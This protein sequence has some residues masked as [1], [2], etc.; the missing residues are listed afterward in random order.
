MRIPFEKI[1]DIN[2]SKSLWRIAV[3]VKDLWLVRHGKSNKQHLEMVI[4]DDLGDE[5]QLTLPTEFYEKLKNE[6]QLNMT[7]TLQNFDVEKNKDKIRACAHPFKLVCTGDLLIDVIGAFHEIGYTQLLPGAR[8]LQ[9]NFKL[10][11]LAGNILNCTLWEDFAKQFAK[12]NNER[13]DWGPTIVLM[14]NAKHL[15]FYHLRFSTNVGNYRSFQMTMNSTH[16][17][18]SFLVLSTQLGHFVSQFDHKNIKLS[19][20]LNHTVTCKLQINGTNNEN[21]NNVTVQIGKGWKKFCELNR[22][23]EGNCIEFTSEEQMDTNVLIVEKVY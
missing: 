7:C 12:Y 1:R 4:C 14:H 6:L 17:N 23:V 19:G 2:D 3:R 13:T 18:S 15:A 11:D 21:F 8:K 5:I 9:V 16:V 10:K 20:P 22:I